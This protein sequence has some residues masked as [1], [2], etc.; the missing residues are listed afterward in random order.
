MWG[1]I[2]KQ[3]ESPNCW[4]QSKGRKV[5]SLPKLLQISLYS[6]R[7]LRTDKLHYIEPNLPTLIPYCWTIVISQEQ[8]QISQSGFLHQNEVEEP[9]R[10][11]ALFYSC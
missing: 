10:R 9:H 5:S 4:C 2:Q 11:N 7:M 3:Q 1:K 8:L 6:L